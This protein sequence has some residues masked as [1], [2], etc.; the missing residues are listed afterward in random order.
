MRSLAAGEV[1]AGTAGGVLEGVCKETQVVSGL[2][3]VKFGVGGRHLRV[4][5]TRRNVGEG[6]VCGVE[7]RCAGC[8]VGGAG[9][10][11]WEKASGVDYNRGRRTS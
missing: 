11:E 6:A 1:A 8:R 10:P 3:R 4:W 2:M 5:S 7:V 9:Q